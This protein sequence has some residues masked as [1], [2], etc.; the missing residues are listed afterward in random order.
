LQYFDYSQYVLNVPNGGVSLSLNGI[1]NG[2]LR[3]NR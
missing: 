2:V 3:G 1:E